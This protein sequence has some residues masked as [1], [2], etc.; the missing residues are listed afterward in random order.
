MV[1]SSGP[2][3]VFGWFPLTSMAQPSLW[4]NR[5]AQ[6]ATQA[7]AHETLKK[8]VKNKKIK[9]KIKTRVEDSKTK[10]KR[11]ILKWR[12][13]EKKKR[14]ERER[15]DR[16]AAAHTH[17]RKTHTAISYRIPKP[18]FVARSCETHATATG[19]SICPAQL[20]FS[21]APAFTVHRYLTP[22][23]P[24]IMFVNLII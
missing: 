9:E 15:R 3:L 8:N 6:E 14:K 7:R 13:K 24:N 16:D 1:F 2:P 22:S 19:C 12:K 5:P 4:S 18:S 20:R 21:T 23:K 11:K 10:T 17:L